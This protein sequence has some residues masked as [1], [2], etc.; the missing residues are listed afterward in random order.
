MAKGRMLSKSISTSWKVSRLDE[1]AQLLFTW[2]IPHTDDF[3]YLDGMPEV[4]KAL[5]MPL[6]K[7]KTEDFT[8]ALV[9]M[10]KVQLIEWY[11]ESGKLIIQIINHDREQTNLHKRTDPRF[12]E[13]SEQSR[14]V[15]SVL[16]S[17][18]GNSRKFRSNLTELNLTELNLTQP[19]LLGERSESGFEGFWKSYPRKKSK[20]QAERAWLKIKPT[21]Q[22]QGQILA[23]LERAKTS[24]DWAKEDG[25]FIPYPATWLNAK[26][27][28]DEIEEDGLSAFRREAEEEAREQARIPGSP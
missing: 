13:R 25:R 17:I 19:P 6:T 8:N 20:G 11:I 16:E 3:G 7:R 28:E 21:E 22:L 9:Q 12:L 5:V 1:F 18:P 4:V 2:M 27:W 23:A 14:N 26:G 24:T 15:I 10:A